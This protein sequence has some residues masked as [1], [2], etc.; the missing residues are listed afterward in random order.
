MN[1]CIKHAWSGYLPGSCWEALETPNDRWVVT[2]TGSDSIKK[3]R[4]VQFNLLTGQLLING[5][6]LKRLLPK[7][8]VHPTYLRT[9]GDVR[10]YK[11]F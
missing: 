10:T 9:F 1:N 3:A 5:K 7:Y 11:P 8:R 6:P 4:D 2:E